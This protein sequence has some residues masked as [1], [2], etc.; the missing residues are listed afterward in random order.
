MVPTL[1]GTAARAPGAL[2]SFS[3]PARAIDPATGRVRWEH[4]FRGYPSE[5]V[6]DLSGG[7]AMTTASGL[8][9]SADNDGY[10][11]AFESAT[12][13]QLWRFQIGAP[14]WDVAPITY[15]LD[16]FQWVAVPSGV[17]LTAFALPGERSHLTRSPATSGRIKRNRFGKSSQRSRTPNSNTEKLEGLPRS[18]DPGRKGFYNSRLA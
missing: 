9:F 18:I 3:L 17:T 7:G 6:L 14:I 16:G 12:G 4:R 2:V 8:V 15:M 1:V 5:M 13:K 11:C 10:L